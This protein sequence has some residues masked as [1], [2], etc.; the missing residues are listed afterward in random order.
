MYV[1]T[2]NAALRS[3]L[4]AGTYGNMSIK[5]AKNNALGIGVDYRSVYGTIYQNLY[6]LNPSTFFGRPID[7]FTDISTTP[8]E[9]S[10]LSYS[11]QPSGQTPILNVELT[12][13][14]S[15]F[16]PGKAG[17]TRLL[18]GTGPTNQRITRL[19]ERVVPG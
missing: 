18:S 19:S 6:G 1:I 14:G 3:Q 5:N 12:V 2:S 9:I 8:N 13:T 15:N 4:Q 16:D 7:L 10:L 17:Y 11:Y